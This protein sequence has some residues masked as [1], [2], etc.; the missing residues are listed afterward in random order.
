MSSFSELVRKHRDEDIAL[1]FQCLDDTIKNMCETV[2]LSLK[3]EKELRVVFDHI[4]TEV[5]EFILCSLKKHTPEDY[6]FEFVEDR[7]DVV[8]TVVIGYAQPIPAKKYYVIFTIKENSDTWNKYN[9]MINENERLE[10]EKR[11]TEYFSTPE[12]FCK[13]FIH[14]NVDQS[15]GSFDPKYAGYLE[16][17][18]SDLWVAKEKTLKVTFKRGPLILQ[19]CYYGDSTSCTYSSSNIVVTYIP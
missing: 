8:H 15:F 11:V 7:K 13:R 19:S 12:E 10:L 16:A 4:T 17:Y 5:R 1:S 14:G 18:I 2:S 9:E 6:L 3:E